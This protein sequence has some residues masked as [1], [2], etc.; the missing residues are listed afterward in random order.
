MTRATATPSRGDVGRRHVEVEHVPGG[1]HQ[2]GDDLPQL[3]AGVRRRA[4]LVGPRRGRGRGQMGEP[5]LGGGRIG[6]PQRVVTRLGDPLGVRGEAGQPGRRRRPR[7]RR[8]QGRAHLRHLVDRSSRG[9]HR[10]EAGA[11]ADDHP[12]RAAAPGGGE[13]HRD[14]VGR[15]PVHVDPDLPARVRRGHRARRLVRHF[16]GRGALARP[17]VQPGEE[18]GVALDDF[19]GGVQHRL[20]QGAARGEAARGRPEQVLGVRRPESDVRREQGNP[21]LVAGA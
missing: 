4:R 1:R 6:I 3:L 18:E 13:H 2:P 14:G 19:E 12:G 5:G 21:H 17:A 11:Q 9:D 8:P 15:Q 10:V 16:R 20:G 7:Q